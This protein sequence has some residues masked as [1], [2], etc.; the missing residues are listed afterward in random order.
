MNSDFKDLLGILDQEAE[1]QREEAGERDEV[2]HGNPVA[3]RI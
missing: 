1:E 2:S 3:G